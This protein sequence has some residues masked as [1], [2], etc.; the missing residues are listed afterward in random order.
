MAPQ[1]Q[2]E[3]LVQQDPQA[4]LEPRLLL[5]ARQARLGLQVRLAFPAQLVRLAQP[6]Q[7]ERRLMLLA[8]QVRL[9]Q[10]GLLA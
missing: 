5:L 2:P 7:L 3:R 6:A 9:V 8:R 10:L 1:A 4:Q